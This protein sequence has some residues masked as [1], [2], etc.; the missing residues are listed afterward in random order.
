MLRRTWRWNEY[1]EGGL[2]AEADLDEP[3]MVKLTVIHWRTN[4][5]GEESGLQGQLPFT[6]P[7][8]G[9]TEGKK[10]WYGAQVTLQGPV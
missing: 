4:G 7:L 9:L 5:E 10:A 1:P 2:E 3:S 8:E 6:L